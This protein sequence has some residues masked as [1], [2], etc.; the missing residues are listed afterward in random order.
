MYDVIVVGGGPS[1][2]IAAHGLAENKRTVVVLDWRKNLGDKLCT[3][4]IGA[5]CQERFPPSK[6]HVHLGAKAVTVVSPDGKRYKVTRKDTQAFVVDRVSYV[7]SLA[8]NAERVGAQFELERRVISVEI[9]KD[10]VTVVASGL[11]GQQSYQARLLIVASGF[12][13]QIL[14]MVGLGNNGNQPFMVGSQAEIIPKKMDDV[15][16]YLGHSIVPG[17]FGWVVPVNNSRA[18]VGVLARP[19]VNGPIER[20][21]SMLQQEDRIV[22]IL[23]QPKSWGIPLRPLTKTYGD[24]VLVV[25]DAAGMAKPTTGGGIYYS[26]L[27]GELAAEVADDALTNRDVSEK[28]LRTYQKKWKALF[29]NEVR[30]GYVARKLYESLSDEQV[31]LLL[32]AV[33]SSESRDGIIS[34]DFSFDWH[35]GLIQRVIKDETLGSVVRSFGPSIIPFLSKLGV[36]RVARR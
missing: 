27:S 16:V 33:V 36:N 29:G 12:R 3:G 2:S 34:S 20:F 13:S 32:G 18:L 25:G 1:G 11:N 15:E 9:G 5:E 31:G 4:I 19:D 14:N 22:E 30:M 10:A 17:S 24:R 8:Q 7:A 28:R 6:K 35:S 26:L 21:I 23:K